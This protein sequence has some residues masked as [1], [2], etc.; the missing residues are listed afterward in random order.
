MGS[1]KEYA[2]NPKETED[3]RQGEVWWS[4]DILVVMGEG[5]MESKTVRAWAM[6]RIKSE[7]LKKKLKKV[8]NT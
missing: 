7:V 6:R 2:A 8:K 3:I 1:V 5:G 4:G